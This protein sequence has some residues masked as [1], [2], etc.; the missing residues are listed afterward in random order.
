MLIGLDVYDE[1]TEEHLEYIKKNV[2]ELEQ[3]QVHTTLFGDVGTTFKYKLKN[4]NRSNPKDDFDFYKNLVNNETS[5]LISSLSDDLLIRE[6]SKIF[7]HLFKL[8]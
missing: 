8:E 3:M 1:V 4:I 5:I 2:H 7:I 6:W